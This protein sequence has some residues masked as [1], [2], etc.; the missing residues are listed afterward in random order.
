MWVMGA[1]AYV[2]PPAK[3]SKLKLFFL[4]I[5]I[6]VLC[7]ISLT[8]SKT[9]TNFVNFKFDRG[10]VEILLAFFMCVLIRQLLLFQPIG[11]WVKVNSLFSQ[12]AKFSYT[13]YLTHMV[14][15]YWMFEYFIKRNS[16]LIDTTSIFTWIVFVLVCIVVSFAIYYCTER[17]TNTVKQYLKRK[18]LRDRH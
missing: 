16:G 5:I 4:P 9:N 11:I 3:K 1:L 10:I 15:E 8:Q 17:H 2:L 12:M 7:A 13:L 14:T 6:I 18:L